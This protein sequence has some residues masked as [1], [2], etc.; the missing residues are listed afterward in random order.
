[1]KVGEVH[2]L[3]VVFLGRYLLRRPPDWLD[4]KELETSVL[5]LPDIL[6][7]SSDFVGIP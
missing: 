4:V 6:A 1:M 5:A 2:T 7:E 3:S